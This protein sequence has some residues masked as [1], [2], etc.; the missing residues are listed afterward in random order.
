MPRRRKKVEE[1][2]NLDRWLVSF[3]DFMTLLFA[4]F[5]VRYSISSVNTGKYRVLSDSLSE[6]F[7][8]EPESKNIID[9]ENPVSEENVLQSNDYIKLAIPREIV[10]TDNNSTQNPS[11]NEIS[12]DVSDAVDDLISDGLISLSGNDNWLEI[13]IKSSLLF[14]SGNSVLS[15]D[16]EDILATLGDI[17][18]VY[19]NQIQVEG[20]TDNVPIKTRKFPSNWELS[21][22]RA[23]SVVHLFEEVG[24][25]PNNM[26]AIGFGEYKNKVSNDTQEGRSENR[27]VK[28]VI[29]GSENKRKIVKSKASSAKHIKKIEANPINYNAKG[30]L[31]INF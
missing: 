11:L 22:A 27:R 30:S 24:V 8:K 7:R 17:I 15:E 13:E 29:L 2:E 25:N 21:S 31:L 23:A 12:A 1:H 3:A 10:N 16:A 4:F 14:Q 26:Q 9:F 19:P 6:S 5:V 20:Y 18:K 28:I